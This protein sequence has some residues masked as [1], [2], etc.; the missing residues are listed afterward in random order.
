MNAYKRDT[1]RTTYGTYGELVE[2][3]AGRAREHHGHVFDIEVATLFCAALRRDVYER[4]GAPSWLG[5][6]RIEW[7]RML[8]ARRGPGDTAGAE[9]LLGQALTGAEQFGLPNVERRA[10]ALL[11]K[12]Q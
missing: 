3:E 4:I 6:T 2:L 12:A 5:Y 10:R 7:A 11:E 8:L 9:D 1:Y